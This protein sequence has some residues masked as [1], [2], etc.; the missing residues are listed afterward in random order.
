MKWKALISLAVL[1]LL[2]LML[3][4]IDL[5]QS[6]PLAADVN[7]P[8]A[9]HDFKLGTRSPEDAERGFPS[10]IAPIAP[11]DLAPERPVTEKYTLLFRT[12]EGGLVSFLAPYDMIDEQVKKIGPEYL[13]GI[14][15]PPISQS[16]ETDP[17]G[18]ALQATQEATIPIIK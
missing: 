3:N 10:P 4:V 15:H 9:T 1:F 8:T 12:D 6:A 2:F 13:E 11:I 14:F 7:E 16:D 5:P 18:Q 17:E